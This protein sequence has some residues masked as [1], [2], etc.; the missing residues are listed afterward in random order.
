MNYF[1][2]RMKRH[3]GKRILGSLYGLRNYN[4]LREVVLDLGLFERGS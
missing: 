3:Y 1:G 4:V 2:T